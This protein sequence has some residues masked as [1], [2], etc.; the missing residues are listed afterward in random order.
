MTT[1][2]YRDGIM[3]GDSRAWSGDKHPIGS[4]TKVYQVNGFLVGISSSKVGETTCFLNFLKTHLGV[5]SIYDPEDHF[6]CP[7]TIDADRE[8]GV[9][10]LVVDKDGSAYYWDDGQAFSGP[11]RA[12]YYAIGSGEQTAL[13]AMVL[14]KS[15]AEA[16]ELAIQ[17][18][19][20]TGGEVETVSH[21]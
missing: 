13:A 17:L 5:K 9:Q 12:D 18:D 20:W 14:G 2:A 1:I 16:V 8:Y 19:P 21:D 15:A 6:K 10:A 7:T 11:L 4:K 3:A